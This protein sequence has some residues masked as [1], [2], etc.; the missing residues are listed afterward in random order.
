MSH[1]ERNRLKLLVP[2]AM[3]LGLSWLMHSLSTQM[4]VV[5]SAHGSSAD[6]TRPMRLKRTQSR[7]SASSPTG[8]AGSSHH[9]KAARRLSRAKPSG[10]LKRVTTKRIITARP[11]NC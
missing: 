10:V 7:M 4:V 3:V 5:E 1:W 6:G 11:R 9:G 8:M 2:A